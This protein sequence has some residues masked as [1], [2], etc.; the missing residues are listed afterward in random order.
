MDRTYRTLKVARAG[1]VARAALACPERRNAFDAEMIGELTAALDDLAADDSLR[2]L[3][4]AGEGP[5]FCAGAD[6]A[7]MR[8]AGELD[9]AAGRADAAKLAALFR[10]LDRFPCPTIV[11]AHGAALGGGAGLVAAADIAIAEEGTRF[12]FTEVRLGIIPAVISTFALSAIGS[13]AAR[14]YF[15]TGEL[16]DAA[17]ARELG[18][19]SE[20]VPAGK[21]AERAGEIVAALQAVGPAASRAA[22]RLVAEVAPL[23]VDAA[24]THC[25]ARIAAIR[26]TPEAQEGLAAFLEKRAPAWT[27]RDV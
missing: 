3:V 11:V 22:K 6:A 1:G 9:E 10:A 4:L 13:R 8:R 23:D 20:T 24:L 21:G 27:R 17:R 2:A 19:V 5:T 14:R 25:A 18:L 7:W 26:R 16:F 15:T 12:G